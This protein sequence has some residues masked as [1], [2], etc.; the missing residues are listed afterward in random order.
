MYVV[1]TEW[2]HIGFK[3]NSLSGAP[4]LNP[5]QA[6]ESL[7]LSY[8]WLSYSTILRKLYYFSNFGKKRSVGPV[9]RF[10]K[11]V[12]PNFKKPVNNA[13]TFQT[14]KFYLS[15]PNILIRKSIRNWKILRIHPNQIQTNFREPPTSFWRK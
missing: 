4:N 6:F 11:L 3:R 7:L 1:W 15:H 8:T 9:E 12:S 13:V 2:E 10:F 5:F 14:K